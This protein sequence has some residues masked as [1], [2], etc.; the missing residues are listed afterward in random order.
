MTPEP[1]SK[2]LSLVCL[3][4]VHPLFL[5]ITWSVPPPALAAVFLLL[6]RPDIQSH[7][8]RERVFIRVRETGASFSA[9]CSPLTQLLS[10]MSG[11][12]EHGNNDLTVYNPPGFCAAAEEETD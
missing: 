6:M 3:R 5:L 10:G 2:P 8:C 4:S 9:H 7:R 11:S 1:S 12:V